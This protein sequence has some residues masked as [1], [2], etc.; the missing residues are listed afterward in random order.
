MQAT[1]AVVFARCIAVECDY[2]VQPFIVP[3]RD[4]ETHKPM[5]GVEV[6]D[7]GTKIGYN[8][9]DNGYLRFFHYR[10][11]R[12]ALL[13]RFVS[14]NKIGDFKMKANPKIIYQIMV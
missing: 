5:P 7:I 1:H 14:I 6:G 11:P 12:K 9:I 13:S 8:A 3:V 10:V 2:G 4:M